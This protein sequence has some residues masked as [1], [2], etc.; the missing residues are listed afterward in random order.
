[1]AMASC[2]SKGWILS[3]PWI[4]RVPLP[5]NDAE[6]VSAAG[7]RSGHVT[8]STATSRLFTLSWTLGSTVS[9]VK[10]TLAPL[11]LVRSTPTCQ[12]LGGGPGRD[13]DVEET[14]GVRAASTLA[15]GAAAPP[16]PA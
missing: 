1:M 15:G 2:A 7:P 12:D 14:G 13:V 9:S 16:P 4:L 8:W 6:S 3:G 5:G 10:A 11:S